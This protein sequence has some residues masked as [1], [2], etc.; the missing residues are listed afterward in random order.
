MFI[1]GT[2]NRLAE[3]S[4]EY[5]D[6]YLYNGCFDPAAAARAAAI[7]IARIAFAPRRDF[8]GVPSRSIIFLSSPRWSAASV[9]AIALAIS[10]LALATAFSTPLPKYRDLSPSRSSSAS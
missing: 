9:P 7:E 2:G 8:V 5:R 4:V 10:P 1:I 3:V 6:K